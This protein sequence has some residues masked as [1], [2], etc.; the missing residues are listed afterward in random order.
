MS[1]YLT[2][3]QESKTL[4]LSTE[5]LTRKQVFAPL[6]NNELHIS[7]ENLDSAKDV[8]QECNGLACMM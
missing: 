6:E 7:F 3:V 1:I 2:L 8:A 5:L 4:V